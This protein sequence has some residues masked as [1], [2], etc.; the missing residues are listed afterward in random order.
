[1]K[2]RSALVLLVVMAVIIPMVILT[3]CTQK[4]AT[5]PPAKQLTFVMVPK[6]V[7]P[8]YIPCYQGFV[9]A[10]AKYG[11]KVEEAVPQQFSVPL[12]V[13]VIEDLIVQKVDGIA[14][15]A[16]DDVGLVPVIAEATKAGIKVITFDAPAPSSAALC[17]IGTDNKSAGSA[18]ATQMAKLMGNKGNLI[19]L[20]GGLT[21]SNLNLR[22]QGFKETM[23]Q[24]APNIKILDVVD[25][26]GDLSV[27][28]T[29]TEAI[30]EAYPKLNAIFAVSAEI[31]GANSAVKD[32]IAKGRLK[33]GQIILGGFDDVT[34]T[35]D[36]I[37]DGTIA[38]CLVQKTYKM[39]WLSIENL[40]AATQ[41]KTLQNIDTGMVIVTKANVATY[42]DD[43]KKE[44]AGATTG[45][46]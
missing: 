26:G 29:K 40:L 32:A 6:G 13:Q 11:I 19:I 34:T 1:M 16:N 44:F 9:D 23:A 15:S 46:S 14:I 27:T 33:Q 17:Y 2:K 10:A 43:M 42:M 39:G 20:Q 24:I 35:L 22:T 4:A 36:G 18:A 38:F 3:S 8:Y 7:H 37:K 31:A 30:L 28:Q 21:A 45:G 12:Q 25:E 5:T 41:G